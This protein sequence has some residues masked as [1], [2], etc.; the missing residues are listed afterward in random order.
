M[1]LPRGVSF[2]QKLVW[3]NLRGYYMRFASS[4]KHSNI[5]LAIDYRQ[6]GQ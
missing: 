4:Y 6:E 2:H 3:V 1:A 5:Y